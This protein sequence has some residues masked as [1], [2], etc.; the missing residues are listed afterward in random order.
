MEKIGGWWKES[1]VKGNVGFIFFSKL[2]ELKHKIRAWVKTNLS[3]V[4]KKILNIESL[5]GEFE[6]EEDERYLSPQESEVN[7]KDELDLQDAIKQE[8]MFWSKKA[9]GLWQS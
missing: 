1:N 3:K 4:E 7:H 6:L 2:K 9:Q 8:D 5:L